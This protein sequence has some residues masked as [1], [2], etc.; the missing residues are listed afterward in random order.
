MWFPVDPRWRISSTFQDHKNRTPPSKAPGVDIACPA[1]TLVHSPTRGKVT[2]SGW[3]TRG[4]RAMWIQYPGF[5]LY[6]CHLSRVV[7]LKGETVQPATLLAMT[8]NTG[9]STGPHLHMSVF[10][11]GKWLDPLKFFGGTNA[12]A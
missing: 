4:G 7:R 1:G 5:R 8:G 6:L 3:Q 11:K 9:T 2:F 10:S 12:S